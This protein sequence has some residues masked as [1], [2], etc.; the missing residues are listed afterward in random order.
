MRLYFQKLVESRGFHVLRV[1]D[2]GGVI[3]TKDLLPSNPGVYRSRLKQQGLLPPDCVRQLRDEGESWVITKAPIYYDGRLWDERLVSETLS[4]ATVKPK[5]G[6]QRR[7]FHGCLV[8]SL[9]KAS[10][11]RIGTLPRRAPPRGQARDGSRPARETRTGP[12]RARHTYGPATHIRP[13]RP[14]TPA[15]RSVRRTRG[16]ADYGRVIL[17]AIWFSRKLGSNTCKSCTASAPDTSANP[18]PE[19]SPVRCA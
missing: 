2:Y 4:S 17:P 19:L 10:P 12:T 18:A 6:E 14:T 11:P 5:A 3:C 8:M 13:A 16:G 7:S 1:Q 15:V 9:L